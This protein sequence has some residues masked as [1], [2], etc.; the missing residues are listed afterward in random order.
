MS[1]DLSTRKSL[2]PAFSEIKEM[3]EA[4]NTALQGFRSAAI[5]TSFHKQ[6]FNVLDKFRRFEKDLAALE[7][8]NNRLY[9]VSQIGQVVNSSLESDIVL[10]IVMDTIIRLTNAE[11]GFLMLKDDAGNFTP[12]VAR[13][14]EQE[15]LEQSEFAVSKTIIQKVVEESKPV[16]TTNAQEDPRF[17]EQN[18]II[19]FNLRSI[20][21][22]PLRV[23]KETIGVIY[24]D[25]RIHQI[26]SRQHRH[27]SVF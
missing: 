5:P 18:S 14:F 27:Q 6:T 19:A 3:L 2:Q 7:D 16:L 23:K 9:A 8:Q 12:K 4:L 15:T 1:E 13:N 20:L 24:A 21:C 10:Q 22:V 25:N 11:R 26:L 17:N